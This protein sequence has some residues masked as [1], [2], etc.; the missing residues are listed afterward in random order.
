[1]PSPTALL[2]RLPRQVHRLAELVDFRQEG[3]DWPR[4]HDYASER[5]HSLGVWI[6]AKRYKRRRRDLDPVKIKLLDD[7]VPRW[8]SGR[9]RGR[10]P[11][12]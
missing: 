1:V 12:P 7:A 11:R 9:I 10:R 8:K 5:Q 3:N 2:P 6:H 4:H